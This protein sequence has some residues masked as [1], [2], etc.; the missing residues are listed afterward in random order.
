MHD[1]H[2]LILIRIQYQLECTISSS[3]ITQSRQ[4]NLCT[5]ASMERI[6]LIILCSTINDRLSCL[7]D[8]SAQYDNLR[9]DSAA[10]ICQESTQQIIILIQNLQ[11][12][13][14]SCITCIEQIFT[15]Q[16]LQIP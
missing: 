13:R 16:I 8:T 7:A 6:F 14:I 5:P 15:A 3:I 4:N 2:S 11:C 10:D 12:S 9:V 1:Q